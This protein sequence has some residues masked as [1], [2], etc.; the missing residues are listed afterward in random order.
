MKIYMDNCCYNRIFDD[1]RIIKNYLEREA[2][3]I[4]FQKIADGEL[5]LNGGD[6]R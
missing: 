2:V 1:R 4:I 3:L 5:E 6:K